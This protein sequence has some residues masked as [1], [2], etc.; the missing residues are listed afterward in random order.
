M[1]EIVP[2][3]LASTRPSAIEARWLS[4][5]STTLGCAQ[6]E[7]VAGM[8]ALGEAASPER[9]AREAER[10]AQ[11]AQRRAERTRKAREREE[12]LEE[13]RTRAASRTHEDRSRAGKLAY[14]RTSPEDRA[15]REQAMREACAK[16]PREVDC[17]RDSPRP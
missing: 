4:R 15:R 10:K 16:V 9:V 5:G 11:A 3:P 14:E 8:R 6:R 12:A 7:L 17:G 13:R 1:G 2:F